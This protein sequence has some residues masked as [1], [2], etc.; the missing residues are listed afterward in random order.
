MF[1]SKDVKSDS[2]LEHTSGPYSFC[3]MQIYIL[4]LLSFKL[5]KSISVTVKKNY[6]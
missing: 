6:F 3:V 1:S 2:F 5:E 4:K